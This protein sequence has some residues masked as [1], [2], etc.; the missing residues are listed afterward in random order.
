MDPT[1]AP[2]ETLAISEMDLRAFDVIGWDRVQNNTATP[3]PATALTL[4]FGLAGL[5][6]A[7]RR[8]LG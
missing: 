6:M 3:E 2:G 1:T 8:K 7:R 4:V 5:A